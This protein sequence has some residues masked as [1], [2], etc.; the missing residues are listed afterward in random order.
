MRSKED[1]G[2]I[3][4]VASCSVR[5]KSKRGASDREDALAH[6]NEIV[7]RHVVF[8]STPAVSGPL[9]TNS[10][11]G[12]RKSAW[13]CRRDEIEASRGVRISRRC[14][15]INRINSRRQQSTR[16]KQTNPIDGS[17]LMA[18]TD[19]TRNCINEEDSILVARFNLP[20]TGYRYVCCFLLFYFFIS[21]KH[22]ISPTSV[23][24]WSQNVCTW[25]ATVEVF[26][27]RCDFLIL[28]LNKY[29]R[30][31]GQSLLGARGG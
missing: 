7:G 31:H 3:Q 21:P 27:C 19:W 24:Q 16:Q 2:L 29:G 4:K 28:P 22:S 13:E 6:L 10:I 11:N 12:L 30:R 15:R 14:C 1:D 23:N 5:R 25:V 17:G 8:L 9:Q 20:C 26:Q 18:A